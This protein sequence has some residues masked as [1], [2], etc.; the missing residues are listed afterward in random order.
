MIELHL[1]L[2]MYSIIILNAFTC[3]PLSSAALESDS[4]GNKRLPYT[5]GWSLISFPFSYT[6]YRQIHQFKLLAEQD[7]WPITDPGANMRELLPNV[8]VYRALL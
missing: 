8:M 5:E 2:T 6:L 1:I 7:S 4:V 3:C